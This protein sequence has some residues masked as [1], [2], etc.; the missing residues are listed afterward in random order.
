MMRP[1]RTK[2]QRNIM[3]PKRVTWVLKYQR[4]SKTSV[5]MEAIFFLAGL[6]FLS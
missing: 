4:A 5:T 1:R 3:R 6:F 2:D